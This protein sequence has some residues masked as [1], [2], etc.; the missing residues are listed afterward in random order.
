MISELI[1]TS[2]YFLPMWIAA[3]WYF[4]PAFRNALSISILSIMTGATIASVLALLWLNLGEFGV[5]FGTYSSIWA[6]LFWVLMIVLIKR[7]YQ[8]R[9]G[10]FVAFCATVL[11]TEVWELPIHVLTIKMNPA[12]EQ[13]M[14]TVALSSCYLILA[15]PLIYEAWKLKWSMT[16]PLWFY[17][18]LL[19][20]FSFAVAAASQSYPSFAAQMT[21]RIL[22]A[23][24]FILFVGGFPKVEKV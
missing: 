18:P 8:P 7:N 3:S 17:L 12:F 22:S 9:F 24:M 16:K 5:V 13:I 10:A 2:F 11:A 4:F 21:L 6:A 14:L 23:I 15:V 19:F 1:K 20:S